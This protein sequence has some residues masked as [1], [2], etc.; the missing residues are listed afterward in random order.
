MLTR[1][2]ILKPII[3]HSSAHIGHVCPHSHPE[4]PQR[5]ISIVRKL[6]E[7]TK[8]FVFRTFASGPECEFKGEWS[9]ID[10]DTYVTNATPAVLQTSRNMIRDAVA[11]IVGGAHCGF[12]LC[13]PPGHHASVDKPGGFCLEN[14]AWYAV[15]RLVSRGVR[16]ICIYDFDVH[17]GDGTERCVR[18]ATAPQYNQ[19]RFVST[20]A[21]GKGIFP[22]TGAAS[23]DS[24]VLNIP[25]K[26]GTGVTPYMKCF[27]E[28]VLPFIAKPEVLI[29]SAGYDAHQDDP[30]KLMNL[31]TDTYR[32]ISE[33]LKNIGSPILFLLEGGYNPDVLAKCVFASLQPWLPA[34]P[35]SDVRYPSTPTSVRINVKNEVLG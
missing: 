19:V 34:V 26:R 30:M 12:V 7:C 2:N 11:D 9:M 20:H 17:H 35:N 3:Y 14:N 13:R 27:R 6:L 33:E 1:S 25:L 31:T 15:E 16:N 8:K 4:D 10:G 22:G 32:Y 29:V 21:Y 5:V 24:K 28:E 18:A 23:R